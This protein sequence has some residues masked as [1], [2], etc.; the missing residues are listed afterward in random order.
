MSIKPLEHVI[1]VVRIKSID[2]NDGNIVLYKHD[3]ES[4]K[5]NLQTNPVWL[6]GLFYP[7]NVNR[8][9]STQ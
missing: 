7:E 6:L 2:L 3:A 4:D 8:H 1:T 5:D 9:P